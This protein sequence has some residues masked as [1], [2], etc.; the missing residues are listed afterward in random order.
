[1]S[2][3]ID[4]V[5]WRL[6]AFSA[7]LIFFLRLFFRSLRFCEA[8]Q[9][10]VLIDAL[11]GFC[12]LPKERK[13][14]PPL[15]LW[16]LLIR[17]DA[18]SFVSLGL[19]LASRPVALSKFVFSRSRCRSLLLLLLLL[20]RCRRPSFTRCLPSSRLVFCRRRNAR[21]WHPLRDVSGNECPQKKSISPHVF[22]PLSSARL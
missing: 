19:S 16:G 4:A 20:L 17:S 15:F 11:G 12:P 13:K 22:C 6:S 7:S 2:L 8:R 5:L 9:R 14:R 3:S 18:T 1:M 10:G 21:S